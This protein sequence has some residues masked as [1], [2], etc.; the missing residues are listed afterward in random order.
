VAMNTPRTRIEWNHETIAKPETIG[1]V[2]NGVVVWPTAALRPPLGL[3]SLAAQGI[4]DTAEATIA[5]A[6]T[7]PAASGADASRPRAVL[8][9]DAFDVDKEG[10]LVTRA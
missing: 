10:F 3:P 2:V 5:I 8:L 7:A 4:P 1:R 9:R 6:A